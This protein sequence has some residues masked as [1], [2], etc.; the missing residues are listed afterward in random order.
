MALNPM[1]LFLLLSLLPWETDLRKHCYN[2][3]QSVFCLWPLLGV[4]AVKFLY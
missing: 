4:Y 1:C 2:L 3:Y